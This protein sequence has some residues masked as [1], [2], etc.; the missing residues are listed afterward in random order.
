MTLC[1]LAVCTTNCLSAVHLGTT[2]PSQL[3]VSHSGYLSTFYHLLSPGWTAMQQIL[4]SR[5]MTRKL[6]IESALEAMTLQLRAALLQNLHSRLQPH[7]WHYGYLSSAWDLQSPLSSAI[8]CHLYLIV[9]SETMV[10]F[11]SLWD[12]D[13]YER[14]LIYGVCR[15]NNVSVES[16]KSDF[17]ES[18][19][20]K[21]NCWDKCAFRFWFKI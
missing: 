6:C 3:W 17:R 21:E 1:S 9:S 7:S 14:N 10:T 8:W 11:I 15:I 13:A 19:V 12:A 2:E 5:H 16:E 18:L 20:L 4:V